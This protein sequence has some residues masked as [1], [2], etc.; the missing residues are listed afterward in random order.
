MPWRPGFK[1]VENVDHDTGVCDGIVDSS[2]A[3]VPCWRNAARW[4]SLLP[5]RTDEVRVNGTQAKP[6]Q[7]ILARAD[8]LVSHLSER[9]ECC[10][11]LGAVP[12]SLLEVS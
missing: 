2:G 10:Q 8:V 3:N 4:G 9:I 1:P 11:C 12:T 6:S 5:S 7:V